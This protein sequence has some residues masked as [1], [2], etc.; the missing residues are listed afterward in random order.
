MTLI[1]KLQ[2]NTIDKNGDVVTDNS[3]LQTLL[4]VPIIKY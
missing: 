2:L 1:D 4:Q 3:S